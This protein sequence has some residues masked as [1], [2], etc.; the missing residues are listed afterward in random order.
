MAFAVKLSVFN[1][2][3]YPVEHWKWEDLVENQSKGAS[4]GVQEL[5]KSF[6]LSHPL[7]AMLQ[8]DLSASK[9]KKGSFK[10]AAFGTSTMC[11]F[12]STMAVEICA[13]RTYYAVERVSTDLDNNR[14]L[15]TN[16]NIS[17]TCLWSLSQ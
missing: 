10:L 4:S 9:I 11:L 2:L 13:K 7:S 5:E 14:S 1:V 12:K 8:L 6:Y 15:V 16:R 17:I 3:A